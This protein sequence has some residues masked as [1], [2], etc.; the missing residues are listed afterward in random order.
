MFN[1]RPM[2]LF[3]LVIGFTAFFC[4]LNVFAGFG[5][6][7]FVAAGL[8]VLHLFRGHV[9]GRVL[10][11]LATSRA[12][13]IGCV[14][15]G[16]LV[17]LSFG[18]TTAIY[19]S[20]TPH[21][22]RHTLSGTVEN[23][24]LRAPEDGGTY[25]TL[26]DASFD[27]Q[28]IDGRVFVS[29][30]KYK[31]SPDAPADAPPPF[32]TGDIVSIKDTT[33]TVA[34]ADQFYV[35]NRLMYKGN[36]VF[37]NVETAGVSREVKHVI[38]RYAHDMF[39]KHMSPKNADV[40]YGMAFGDRSSVDGETDST[41]RHAGLIHVLAVS[42]LHV[43]VLIGAVVGILKVMRIRAKY[44][45]PIVLCL[46]IFY[47]YLC[48]FKFSII[49]ACLMFLIFLFMSCYARKTDTITRLSAAALL[50]L[51]MFPFA[52]YSWSFQLSYA[53]VF[54]IALFGKPLD[55]AVT[56]LIRRA[57][58]PTWFDRIMIYLSKG[59][60]MYVC[61][62]AATFP[63]LIM[64]FG[65][66]ATFGIVTNM[67]F[68]PL[69]VFAFILG[70]F[71]IASWVGQFL[72]AIPNALIEFCRMGTAALTRVPGALVNLHNSGPWFIFFLLAVTALS[73]FIFIKPKYKFAAASVLFVIYSIGFFV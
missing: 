30:S 5:F 26:S 14:A 50:T 16:L 51:I 18:I 3:A 19:S 34:T 53:C 63:L 41:F 47:C 40:L 71:A 12:F 58:L 57:K 9:R 36:A 64:Y 6:I 38:L 55:R 45:F 52:I 70:M 61:V 10:S 7:V 13:F 35:N 43:S 17:L 39:V 65:Y 72:L 67:L 24:K 1:V 28:K 54:G 32:Q 8:F 25:V 33:L 21:Y 31:P 4:T 46:L 11:F 60:T 56:N 62:T 20:I 49:R 22:D 69:M 15:L 29:L 37:A 73:S 42:G 27:G 68:L 23:Y 66:F 44:Q 48:D 59:L 2:C